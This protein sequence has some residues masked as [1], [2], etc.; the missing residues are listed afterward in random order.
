MF[1]IEGEITCTIAI[2]LPTNVSRVKVVVVLQ[3]HDPPPG[4]TVK[5]LFYSALDGN[6][7]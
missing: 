4:R 3:D 1:S 5:C 6:T 7:T 2:E